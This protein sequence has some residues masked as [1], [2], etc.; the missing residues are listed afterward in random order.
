[1]ATVF[2]MSLLHRR[3]LDRWESA[4][5]PD[6]DEAERLVAVAKGW[7]TWRAREVI[8][9]AGSGAGR[10][11][12]WRTTGMTELFTGIE[13]AITAEGD[14]LAVHAKAAAEMLFS[15]TVRDEDEE[16]GP[17]E[18]D[19]PRFLGR[20][21]AAVEDIWFD[22]ARDR[23]SAAPAGDPLGRWNAAWVLRCAG[24]RR[25]ATGRRARRTRRPR[26]PCPGA[27]P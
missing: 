17:G 6:R 5:A 7:I 8:V 18:L 3:A 20:L 16:E 25:T 21:L 13:G 24:W 14:N 9:D 19:D 11:G 1:M 23:I 26:P 15:V 4:P 10:R 2:A 12:C 22:R 27:G